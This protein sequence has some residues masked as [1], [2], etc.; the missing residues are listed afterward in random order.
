[1]RSDSQRANALEVPGVQLCWASFVVLMLIATPLSAQTPCDYQ[2]V[3]GY[4]SSNTPIRTDSNHIETYGQSWTSGDVLGLWTPYVEV[5][6][7]QNGSSITSGAIYDNY[8]NATAQGSWTSTLNS[9]GPGAFRDHSD[10]WFEPDASCASD[11][12]TL[13]LGFT[14]GSELSISRPAIIGP[15]PAP[16]VPAFWWLGSGVLSDG[17]YYAQAAWVGSPNGA[18]GTPTWSVSTQVGGGT[19]ALSCYVCTSTTATST[20]PSNGCVYDIT[21]YLDY[22]G[23]YSDPF[24]V[25]IVQPSS[26]SLVSGFPTHDADG[27]GFVSK[28]NWNLTDTCGISDPGLSGT[29]VFGSR[30]NSD[31]PLNNWNMATPTAIVNNPLSVFED[32]IGI[33]NCNGGCSPVWTNP[34]STLSLVKVYHFPWFAY[35]GSSSSG[36]GLMILSNTTQFYLDHG[37]HN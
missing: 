4:G 31:Y 17:D 35:V 25:A 30:D 20:A 33:K 8:P 10:H 34:Q 7:Q 21:V 36:V 6:Q 5:W 26:F 28:Y 23:F 9:V 27:D 18:S 19:I 24:Y 2:T 1:M 32:Q 11:W 22:G 3:Y 29:E 16:P 37:L 13:H 14:T 12:S 15:T